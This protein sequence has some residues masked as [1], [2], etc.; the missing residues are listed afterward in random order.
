VGGARGAR[1][2]VREPYGWR[3]LWQPFDFYLNHRDEP[4]FKTIGE[5][6]PVEWSIYWKKGLP[7][8][9]AGWPLLALWRWRK[10]GADLVELSS[11]AFFTAIALP[12]Q[13][14]LGLYA[15]VAAPYVSRDLAEWLASAAPAARQ[16]RLG[17]RAA[18]AALACV[19]VGLAEWARPEM[20]LGIG[21]MWN[22]YP[23]AA[24]DFMEAHDVRGRG[25]NQFG[26]AGYQLY[27]F[28]P[29]RTR[30]PFIDIHQAGTR[31]TRYV[32]AWVQQSEE[33]WRT[34]HRTYGFDYAARRA[35]PLRA[36]HPAQPARRRQHMGHG[37]HGRRDGALR[38][39]R[40]AAGRP[41]AR[42]RLPRASGGCYAAG[43]AG[44]IMRARFVVESQGP[45][46]ARACDGR[47]SAAR[48]GAAP[49]GQSRAH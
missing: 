1:D 40:R 31:D 30:L 42:S 2:L 45:R 17:A 20:P 38:A 3:A 47:I 33:A 4:I 39:A 5:L 35:R 27:R 44:R 36:L 29:D 28:W 26:F 22:K 48:A 13:R 6:G 16:V 19:A 43:T 21:F 15:L 49:R 25:F 7:F 12:A 46:G 10:K 32:Y 24:C 9:V 37:L 14:F 18:L 8:L 23:V 41:G 34:L 11:C